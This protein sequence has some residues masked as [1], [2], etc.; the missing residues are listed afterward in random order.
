MLEATSFDFA[1]KTWREKNV[2]KPLWAG[3]V[4]EKPLS[5]VR[6]LVLDVF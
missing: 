4:S 3:L 1:W 2:E 5:G 6:L